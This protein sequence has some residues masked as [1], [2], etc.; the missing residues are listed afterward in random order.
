MVA[1]G[2]AAFPHSV[3]EFQ[4]APTMKALNHQVLNNKGGGYLDFQ[5]F[6]RAVYEAQSPEH[7]SPLMQK[8]RLEAP[9]D[10]AYDLGQDWRCETNDS[11][12][13]PKRASSSV[14]AGENPQ[15]QAAQA[16]VPDPPSEA[17]SWKT[18][19]ERLEADDESDAISDTSFTPP[20][21]LQNLA[22]YD[23]Y[24]HRQV[25]PPPGY[26]NA[27]HEQQSRFIRDDGQGRKH[28]M[29]PP[30]FQGALPKALDERPSLP[31]VLTFERKKNYK[32]DFEQRQAKLQ[33]GISLAVTREQS[34]RV[35]EKNKKKKGASEVHQAK[36]K[37]ERRASSKKPARS[38]PTN[39]LIGGWESAF[40][41][42]VF[43]AEEDLL[44]GGRWPASTF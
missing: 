32:R 8:D 33:S 11:V 42:G 17:N 1:D 23:E 22:R 5:N 14:I 38:P 16:Q 10:L 15:D 26:G 35:N 36:P 27:A 40:L 37:K 41:K 18:A 4:Q 19:I 20:K 43:D 29:P 2:T 6:L 30:G 24:G 7:I 13:H 39:R 21:K 12:E 25:L 3:K 28:L 34:Q 44:Y 9:E 31:A